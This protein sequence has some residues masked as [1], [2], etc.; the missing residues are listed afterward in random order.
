MKNV[1]KNKEGVYNIPLMQA[2]NFSRLPN[3]LPIKFG[4]LHFNPIV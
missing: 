3:L 4:A 1:R 2:A